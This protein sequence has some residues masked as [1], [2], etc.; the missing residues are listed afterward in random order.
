[1]P[2]ALSSE[3]MRTDGAVIGKLKNS[4]LGGHKR[5]RCRCWYK[6]LAKCT[7]RFLQGRLDLSSALLDGEE[8]KYIPKSFKVNYMPAQGHRLLSVGAS[9]KSAH[10]AAMQGIS[11]HV[12]ACIADLSDPAYKAHQQHLRDQ[13][14]Q[15]E[16]ERPTTALLLGSELRRAKEDALLRAATSATAEAVRERV[17]AAAAAPAAPVDDGM[18]ELRRN[19]SK[20]TVIV[21]FTVFPYWSASKAVEVLPASKTRDEVKIELQHYGKYVNHGKY[22]GSYMLKSEYHTVHTRQVLEKQLQADEEAAALGE[23]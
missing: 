6:R 20:N 18:D 14:Q 12:G 8:S 5:V 11:T 2:L 4:H 13:R 16:S 3:C 1:M 7:S 22:Q 10:Q 19:R 21:L 23:A 15:E 17:R 9:G